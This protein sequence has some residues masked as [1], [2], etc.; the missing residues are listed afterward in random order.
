MTEFKFREASGKANRK[1]SKRSWRVRSY[2]ARASLKAPS[3][4]Q[5]KRAQKKKR[6]DIRF[7]APGMAYDDVLEVSRLTEVLLKGGDVAKVASPSKVA[8]QYVMRFNRDNNS[9][10]AAKNLYHRVNKKLVLMNKGENFPTSASVKL[11][12]ALMSDKTSTE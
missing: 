10:H 4:A 1:A 6:V 12:N 9:S 7:P 11:Y 8:K 3:S 2:K 5:G